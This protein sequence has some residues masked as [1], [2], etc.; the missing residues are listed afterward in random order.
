ME[1]G[2]GDTVD[3]SEPVTGSVES[4]KVVVVSS[5]VAVSVVVVG[6]EVEVVEGFETVLVVAATSDVM[7]SDPGDAIAVETDSYLVGAAVLVVVPD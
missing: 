7:V 1:L 2:A 4:A 6:S 3:V 5:D